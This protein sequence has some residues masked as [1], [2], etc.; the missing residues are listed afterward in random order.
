MV[1]AFTTS[2]SM[3]LAKLTF[4]GTCIMANLA[5]KLK[6]EKEKEEKQNIKRRRRMKGEAG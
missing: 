6:K 5:K 4:D 2:Y 1:N 3:D